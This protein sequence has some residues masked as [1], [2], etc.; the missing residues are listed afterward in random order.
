MKSLA[1]TRVPIRRRQS[2]TGL[3]FL[4]VEPSSICNLRCT[5]CP[6]HISDWPRGVMSD[7]VFSH[8]ESFLPEIPRIALDGWGE[9]L[10]DPKIF[11]RIHICHE[12]GCY[13]SDRGEDTEAARF[14][15]RSTRRSFPGRAMFPPA[16]VSVIRTNDWCNRLMADIQ[17]PWSLSFSRKR[18]S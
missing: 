14:R 16:A 7:L 5:T 13:T 4:I 8:L 12:A 1:K 3:D 9:P 15:A 11:Q 10:T 2:L 17:P 6:I 18:L